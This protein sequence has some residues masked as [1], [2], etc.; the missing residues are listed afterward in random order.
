MPNVLT[1]LSFTIRSFIL[2]WQTWTD[3]ENITNAELD[4]KLEL[5]KRE[6]ITIKTAL[7]PKLQK[8]TQLKYR[9]ERIGAWTWTL[10][11]LLCMMACG[12]GF[13]ANVNPKLEFSLD[14]KGKMG[15]LIDNILDK[16]DFYDTDKGSHE[17]KCNQYEGL[18]NLQQSL[19]SR[20]TLRTTR[21]RSACPTLPSTT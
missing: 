9:N 10:P 1:G 19:N 5:E 7:G 8:R 18:S 3:H 2:K 4:W 21:R 14:P 12:F 13:L 16:I 17:L 20:T 6:L 11:V 15:H